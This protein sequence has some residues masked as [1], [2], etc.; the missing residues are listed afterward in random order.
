MR[1]NLKNEGDAR[2]KGVHWKGLAIGLIAAGFGAAA[3]AAAA[4]L[5]DTVEGL[6]GYPTKAV[7][8]LEAVRSIR[9]VEKH[10]HQYGERQIRQAHQRGHH[11]YIAVASDQEQD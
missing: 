11:A 10:K 9:R 5:P 1:D 6:G 2:R 3:A 8:Q 7:H 4:Q